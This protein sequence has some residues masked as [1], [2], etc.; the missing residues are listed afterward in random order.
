MLLLWQLL[1]KLLKIRFLNRSYPGTPPIQCR[2]S[3]PYHEEP[4]LKTSFYPILSAL[5]AVFAL[6]T[7]GH[8]DLV[9]ALESSTYWSWAVLWK[10]KKKNVYD[11]TVF[12]CDVIS[13]ILHEEVC[14]LFCKTCVHISL[15]C[16]SPSSMKIDK[17]W[18]KKNAKPNRK[19]NRFRL[20]MHQP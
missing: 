13:V 3:R 20:P 12:C 4:R 11:F 2:E 10:K 7:N 14:W 9:K 17:Y 1:L 5:A 8:V 6:F 16:R 15:P 19:L 18:R